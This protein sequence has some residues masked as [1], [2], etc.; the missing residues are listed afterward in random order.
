M[1]IYLLIG[2]IIFPFISIL[3]KRKYGASEIIPYILSEDD[4]EVFFAVA[5]WVLS[6]VAWPLFVVF[7]I[8]TILR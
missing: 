6:L 2:A 4:V 5:L 7:F 1:M 3:Q 8:I